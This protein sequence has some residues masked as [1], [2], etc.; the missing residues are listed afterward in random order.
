[1]SH[2]SVKGIEGEWPVLLGYQEVTMKDG[3]DLIVRI[4]NGDPLV[5]VWD[6]GRGRTMAWT[7]DIVTPPL[8]T[9]SQPLGEIGKQTI[10]I[11]DAA[12]K[13]GK[14]TASEVVIVPPAL[15]HRES[16]RNLV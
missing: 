16:V 12:I 2:P 7:T 3:A 4:D 6:C 8:T 13:S 10:E 5:A 14:M 1:M 11:L 9:L 15:V